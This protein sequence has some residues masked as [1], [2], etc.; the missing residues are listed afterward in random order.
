[1]FLDDTACSRFIEFD[2]KCRFNGQLTLEAY[3]YAVDVTNHR[4]RN[5]RRFR[6]L[7]HAEDCRKLPQLPA[8]GAWATPTSARL[9]MSMGVA[10]RFDT[11]AD[12]AGA[13]TALM[14]GESLRTVCTGRRKKGTIP[15]TQ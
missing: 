10:L 5:P 13:V 7:S 14:C 12:V 2:K 11:E 8:A 4:A 3:K 15:G 6:Q 1:M 9:L